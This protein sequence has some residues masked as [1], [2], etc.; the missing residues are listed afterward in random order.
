M[1]S[2]VH[3]EVLTFTRVDDN[4]RQFLLC[5]LFPSGLHTCTSAR[6]PG[7][8]AFVCFLVDRA[9]IHLDA[10]AHL[11]QPYNGKPVLHIRKIYYFLQIFTA[12][13]SHEATD[14]LNAQAIS[15]KQ[16]RIH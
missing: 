6:F 15:V 3:F 8:F 1:K 10:C 4:P 5:H 13:L 7:V 11:H 12:I 9:L 14:T 16:R 2:N